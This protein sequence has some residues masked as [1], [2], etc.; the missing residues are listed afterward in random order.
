MLLF[1][2]QQMAFFK[3]LLIHVQKTLVITTSLVPQ[4]FAVNKNLPL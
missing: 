2:V 1:T 3:F 4:D